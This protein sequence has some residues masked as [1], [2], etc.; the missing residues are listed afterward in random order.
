MSVARRFVIAFGFG[1]WGGKL[2][3]TILCCV[4]GVALAVEGSVLSP[5][6]ITET[7]NSGR[8]SGWNGSV[9]QL[10][11]QNSTRDAR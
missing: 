8:V 5:E 7:S 9:F 10:K 6:N 4:E 11:W 2:T 1:G 3:L